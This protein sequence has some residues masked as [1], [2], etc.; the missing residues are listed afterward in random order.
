MD[1]TS[2][3]ARAAFTDEEWDAFARS[4]GRT[5]DQHRREAARLRQ[6]AAVTRMSDETQIF[7]FGDTLLE[8]ADR[9]RTWADDVDA[10]VFRLT[11]QRASC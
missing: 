8:R 1:S 9:H 10:A 5:G 11:A 4:S 7:W 3:T 6:R 2:I